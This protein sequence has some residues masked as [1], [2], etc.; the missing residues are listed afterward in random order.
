[1][2]TE[3]EITLIE[4]IRGSR[5]PELSLITAVEI[6]IDYLKQDESFEEQIAVCSQ[7]YA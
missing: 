5:D 2:M 7:E 3:N 6:I 4:M 1:M